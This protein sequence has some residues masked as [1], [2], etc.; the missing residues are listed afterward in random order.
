MLEQADILFARKGFYGASINDVAAAVNVSKQ[1]LLHHFPTKEK[2]YAEVLQGA[3]DKLMM[4]VSEAQGVSTDPRVQL[5]SVAEQ[6]SRVDEESIRVILLLSRELLDNRDRA[7]K[8]QQW[9][10]K[11]FLTGL[12]AMV[13][14]GQEQGVF[15]ADVHPLSY[16]YQLLGAIQYYLMSLP[17][18]QQLYTEKEYKEHQQEHLRLLNLTMERVLL[19]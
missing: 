4:M 9:F 15:A 8:A 18:L 1:G 2:L 6:M 13:T 12:E 17:T 7:E 14:T 16:I 11:P 19:V 10:L 5:Q 3:A